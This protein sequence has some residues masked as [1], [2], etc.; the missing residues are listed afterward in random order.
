[1]TSSLG[2][3]SQQS[4]EL[5]AY[6]NQAK[7][8]ID[9]RLEILVSRVPEKILQPRLKYCLLSPGKR[10]RPIMVI[11][12]CETSGGRRED[13]LELALS[14]ELVHT[15][16]LV[17]DDFIDG[18]LLRRGLPSLHRKF[19]S[20]QAVVAG[21]ALISLAIHYA[22]GYGP[23][24][25]KL[26]SRSALELCEGELMDLSLPLEEATEQ[27][28]ITKSAKK[29]ASL[30]RSAAQCGCLAAG[31]TRDEAEHLASFGEHFG[32]AYQLR[33]DLEEL[34]SEAALANDLMSGRVTLP[35]VHLY[36]NGDKH[37]RTTLLQAFG[38]DDTPRDV[39]DRILDMLRKMGSLDYCEDLV[40]AEVQ[41][42]V[43]SVSTL[44]ESKYKRYLLHIPEVLFDGRKLTLAFTDWASFS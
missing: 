25:L 19:S 26:V 28:M 31:G 3:Q 43:A 18:D 30:F 20:E 44:R 41:K 37:A 9:R 7:L 35:L 22:S 40:A 23:E 21:D 39:V 2:R 32:M 17:H 27:D 16:S 42:A 14:Y 11:L 6:L 33:D 34:A 29:S 12:A 5:F 1:M 8:E 24:V 10:L 15:A 4:R 13:V 36:R 38:N